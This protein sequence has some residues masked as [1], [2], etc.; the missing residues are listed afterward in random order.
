MSTSTQATKHQTT[1][2]LIITKKS[3]EFRSHPETDGLVKAVIVDVTALKKTPSNYDADRET[4]KLVYESEVTDESGKNYGVW[5]PPYSPSLNEKS[6]F[7]KDLDKILGRPLTAEEEKAF[8]VEQILLG[9]SVQIIVKHVVKDTGTYAQ[10]SHVQPDKSPNPFKGSGKFVREQDRKQPEGGSSASYQRAAGSTTTQ[11]P[12]PPANWQRCKVHL[13][14]HAGAD[15]G[16]LDEK[17]VRHLLEKF[18]PGHQ[19]RLEGKLID[20]KVTAD[21]KRL[22]AALTEAEQILNGNTPSFL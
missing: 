5:S 11:D 3:G 9:H 12:A 2:S 14:P 8:D 1:M 13:G 10:I 17:D 22:A 21:D 19:Q 15:L 20:R 6:S 4:F 16:D 18:L 7:K